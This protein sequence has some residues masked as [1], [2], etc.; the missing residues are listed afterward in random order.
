M[1]GIAGIN[2]NAR[3]ILPENGQVEQ[4]SLQSVTGSKFHCYNSTCRN[5]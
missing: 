3:T 4:K 5:S 1:C 2:S